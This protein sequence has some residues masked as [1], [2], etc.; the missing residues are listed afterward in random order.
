[1]GSPTDLPPTSPDWRMSSLPSEPLPP[2]KRRTWL[3]VLLG[4]IAAIVICCCAF[5][6]WASTA[7]EDTVQR[8]AT[9]FTDYMT[10]TSATSE[11]DN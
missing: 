11:A 10:E 3:W 2:K 7:G 4:V 8:W 9:E 5:T 6:V 1:M